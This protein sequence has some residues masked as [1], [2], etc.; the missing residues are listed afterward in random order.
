[1][2]E[3]ERS[4]PA[5]DRTAPEFLATTIVPLRQRIQWTPQRRNVS[6]LDRH[7]AHVYGPEYVKGW[8]A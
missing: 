3:N 5:A 6:A 1:M 4:R 7:I 2:P 8:T